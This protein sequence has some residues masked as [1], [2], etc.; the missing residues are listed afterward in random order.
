MISTE[1]L[2]IIGLIGLNRNC[3]QASV[4]RSKN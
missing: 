2:D 3:Q 1:P 4:E